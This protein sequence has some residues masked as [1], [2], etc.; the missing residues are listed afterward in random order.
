MSELVLNI[1]A[2]AVGGMALVICGEPGAGKSSLALG[3]IDR[4]ATLI[5]D[6]AV[7]FTVQDN[8]LHAAPP[9]RHTGLIEIRNVGLVTVPA[10]CAVCA[11]AITLSPAAQRLPEGAGSVSWCGIDLPHIVLH[12]ALPQ[13]VLRAEYALKRYGER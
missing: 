6:D 12:P 10:T 3:L 8:R 4:G 11:L 7:V 5:G 1:G 13:L 9:P 2:V